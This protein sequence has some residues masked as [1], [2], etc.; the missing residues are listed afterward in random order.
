MKILI[1]AYLFPPTNEV[2][3]LRPYGWAKYWSETGHE[4]SVIT[5]KDIPGVL[6]NDYNLKKVNVYKIPHND[7]I[8]QLK[9]KIKKL[10][11]R[12]NYPV[13]T[14]TDL[15]WVKAYKKALSIKCN[16]VISTYNPYINHWIGYLLKR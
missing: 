4:V 15:W 2:G 16:F 1:I 10:L 14:I 8:S 9:Y 13:P 3:A 6:K 7:L 11:G 12:N 5:A